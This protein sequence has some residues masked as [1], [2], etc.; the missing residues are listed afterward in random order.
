MAAVPRRLPNPASARQHE[1]ATMPSN[2]RRQAV[3]RAALKRLRKLSE[4]TVKHKSYR[5]SNMRNCLGKMLIE[6]HAQKYDDIC[7][8]AKQA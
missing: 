3:N 8:A 1:P 5:A 7:L 6:R 2:K 4:W